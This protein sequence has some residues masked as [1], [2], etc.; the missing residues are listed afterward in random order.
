MVSSHRAP[1][2]GRGAE[3]YQAPVKQAK[4]R[5]NAVLFTGRT[6]DLPLFPQNMPEH[7]RREEMWSSQGAAAGIL[8]RAEC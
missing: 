7:D 6:H 3:A 5:Q 8:S 1:A 4:S 2:P